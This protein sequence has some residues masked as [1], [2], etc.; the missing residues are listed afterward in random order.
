M[1]KMLLE[2]DPSYAK[3]ICSIRGKQVL[4]FKLKK[5]VY[6]TLLGG[7][8]FYEKLTNQLYNWDYEIN[9]Y[10]CCTFNKKINNKQ[11]TIQFHIDDLKL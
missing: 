3:Y 4:F 7:I 2:I 9:P 10:D 8:L 6:G 1:V 11:M 5:A